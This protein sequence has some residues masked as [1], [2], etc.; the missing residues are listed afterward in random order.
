ML[1]IITIPHLSESLHNKPHVLSV[2][3][4]NL[5]VEKLREL[6]ILMQQERGKPYDPS[7]L[8]IYA[9]NVWI[10]TQL[11]IRQSLAL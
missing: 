8:N 10:E 2:L 5:S 4:F 3:K 1:L 11:M 9:K 7:V 6:R